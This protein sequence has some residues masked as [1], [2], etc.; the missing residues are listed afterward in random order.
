MAPQPLAALT[1]DDQYEGRPLKSD[2]KD[3]VRPRVAPVHPLLAE[4]L[5]GWCELWELHYGRK[6]HAED[7][8]VPRQVTKTGSKAHTKSS[9]Y[10]AW[11]RLCDIAGVQNRSLHSTRH[12]F[13]TIARRA[14]GDEK[15]IE[16]VTHNAK[17]TTLDT[18]THWDWAPICEDISLISLPID[19]RRVLHRPGKSLQKTPLLLTAQISVNTEE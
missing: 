10:K 6:P 8:I 7:F 16:K 12:T 9:A 2:G 18:Y 13:A 19:A 15:R 11:R 5:K 1:I 17:G 14:G 4:I 3:K